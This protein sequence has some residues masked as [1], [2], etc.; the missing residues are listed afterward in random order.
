[1]KCILMNKNTKILLAEYDSVNGVFSKI[2]EIYNIDKSAFAWPVPGKLSISNK[3]L[4][5]T[6]KRF[7][8]IINLNLL[9]V[10]AIIITINQNVIEELVQW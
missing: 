7:Y 3:R 8:S 6:N 4:Y 1:M 5:S 10:G 9:M 2:L